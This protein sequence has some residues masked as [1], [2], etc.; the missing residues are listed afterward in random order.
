MC[1]DVHLK[2]VDEALDEYGMELGV[3]S[4]DKY[5]ANVQVLFAYILPIADSAAQQHQ[6]VSFT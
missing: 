3:H 2:I 1:I 5:R 6:L 4:M